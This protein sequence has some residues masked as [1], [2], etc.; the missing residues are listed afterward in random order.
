MVHGLAQQWHRS[1]GGVLV[2]AGSGQLVVGGTLAA[3]DAGFTEVGR[4]WWGGRRV[5]GAEVLF[6]LTQGAVTARRVA[7]GGVGL[8]LNVR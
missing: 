7:V 6:G 3:G 1:P 5:D 2:A 4:P 8:A